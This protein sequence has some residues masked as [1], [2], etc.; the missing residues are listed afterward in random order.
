MSRISAR[1][2]SGGG[3]PPSERFSLLTRIAGDEAQ[4]TKLGRR[5]SATKPVATK[6]IRQRRLAT[7][8]ATEAQATKLRRRKLR[9]RSSGDE[10]Q[11][12]KLRRKLRRRSSGDEAQAATLVCST[13]R[14]GRSRSTSF[15]QRPTPTAAGARAAAL[16]DVVDGFRAVTNG[17]P[18]VSAMHALAVTDQHDEPNRDADG[19]K[20]NFIFDGTDHF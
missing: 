8:P 9:R 20:V 4:A 2:R 17:V 5:S 1:A 6:L 19:L 10:A 7:K 14:S 13:R 16:P 3:H 12:T 18:D 11:A 15:D